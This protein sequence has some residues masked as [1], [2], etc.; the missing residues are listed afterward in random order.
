MDVAVTWIIGCYLIAGIIGM[1]LLRSGA[2]KHGIDSPS[3]GWRYFCRFALYCASNL[4][5]CFLSPALYA[6]FVDLESRPKAQ[7]PDLVALL[8]GPVPLAVLFYLGL[9]RFLRGALRRERKY[10][11][12]L[13]LRPPLRPTASPDSV[14]SRSG[15]FAQLDLSDPQIVRE[16]ARR[17][18]EEINH[19][20]ASNRDAAKAEAGQRQFLDG[21][22]P[23]LEPALAARV[24]ELYM[25]ETALHLKGFARLS[26]IQRDRA[27]ERAERLRRYNRNALILGIGLTAL[28]IV[29]LALDAWS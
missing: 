16:L 4:A 15:D 20:L 22:V 8:L 28:L 5:S 25:E 17:H 26:A 2:L 14:R 27:L 23:T 18:W 1:I 13:G 21:F 9:A 24:N 11:R 10:E 19:G 29:S 6:A 12:I 3:P 7:S